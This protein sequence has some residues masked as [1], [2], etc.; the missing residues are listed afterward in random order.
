MESLL[1]GPV[2][3]VFG[4]MR[5][6]GLAD[7]KLAA[8]IAQKDEMQ[9]LLSDLATAKQSVKAAETAIQN[10]VAPIIKERQ[11]ELL[12]QSEPEAPQQLPNA[13]L[14]SQPRT[15]PPSAVLNLN[16]KADQPTDSQPPP[17]ARAADTNHSQ[18]EVYTVLQV[19]R[20]FAQG[21][22]DD[23]AEQLIRACRV[24]SPKCSAVQIAE[25]LELK[26]PLA[27]GKESPVGFLLVAVPKLFKGEAGR[28]AQENGHKSE[29]TY[30][31][32]RAREVSNG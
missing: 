24:N 22:D 29:E 4:F 30:W 1:N 10:Y 20:R 9:K 2:Q 32:R 15:H 17:T 12:S 31:E 16:G 18:A 11:A 6:G 28:M 27:K 13:G 8:E 21:A 14:V 5:R 25:A 26:G 19:M 3:Q 23:A 7:P